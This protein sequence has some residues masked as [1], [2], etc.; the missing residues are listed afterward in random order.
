MKRRIRKMVE[1]I[2]YA[3]VVLIPFGVIAY[4]LNW[5]IDTYRELVEE[6]EEGF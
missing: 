2:L 6:D 1:S 4:L 5:S 3:V